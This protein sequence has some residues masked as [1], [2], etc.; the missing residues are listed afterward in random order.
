MCDKPSDTEIG[1]SGARRTTR[2]ASASSM[3]PRPL[4]RTAIRVSTDAIARRAKVSSASCHPFSAS[5]QRSWP[6]A[7]PPVQRAHSRAARSSLRRATTDVGRDA[8][9]VRRILCAHGQPSHGGGALSLAVIEGL[10][11]AGFADTLY[12]TAGRHP[13]GAGPR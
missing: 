9:G 8:D 11:R 7:A 1:A 5:S 4:F 6:P 10:L 13:R 3:P 2:V 12:A